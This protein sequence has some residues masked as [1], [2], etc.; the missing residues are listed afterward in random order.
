MLPRVF[1]KVIAGSLTK[2][3]I[4]GLIFIVKFLSNIW[5]QKKYYLA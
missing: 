3:A 5:S 2:E 1:N 4:F